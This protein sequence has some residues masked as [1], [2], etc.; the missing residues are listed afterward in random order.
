M[1]PKFSSL[2]AGVASVRQLK[3]LMQI[4]FILKKKNEVTNE[5]EYYIFD[6]KWTNSPNK[7]KEELENRKELQLALYQKIL[8]AD[9]KN[10]VMRGYYLLKQAILLTAYT[11][12]VSS[13]KIEVIEQKSTADIFEQAVESYWE[14]IMNLQDGFIEEG[15]EM[16]G[17][18]FANT[19]FIGK[20]EYKK[21]YSANV[22]YIM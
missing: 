5:D 15:E 13:D 14:R 8:E 20:L 18:A 16:P 21:R 3:G 9:G 1:P 7:R 11:D 10:V 4:D 22:L 12:F 19:Q 2:E 6:F 17:T